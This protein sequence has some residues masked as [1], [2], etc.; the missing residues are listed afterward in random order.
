MAN[1]KIPINILSHREPTIDSS[2]SFLGPLNY[3]LPTLQ[4]SY[5]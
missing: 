2:V 3:I 5:V 4:Y 1:H